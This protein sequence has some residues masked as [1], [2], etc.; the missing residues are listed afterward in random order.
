MILSL[1]WDKFSAQG[2]MGAMI[3]GVIGVPI[4]KFGATAIPGFTGVFFSELGELAPAFLLSFIVG[5]LLSY[6][7]SWAEQK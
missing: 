5:V 3:A 6:R 2:A 7:Q 1:A 4:F